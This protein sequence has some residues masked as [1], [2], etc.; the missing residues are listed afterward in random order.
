MHEYITIKSSNHPENLSET[1]GGTLLCSSELHPDKIGIN[2]SSH[3]T[4]SQCISHSS[5]RHTGSCTVA[6]AQHQCPETA[7]RCLAFRNTIY[8]LCVTILSFRQIPTFICL[9]SPKIKGKKNIS[10]IKACNHTEWLQKYMQQ[11]YKQENTFHI[12]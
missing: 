2:C 8:T 11:I 7:Y 6:I 1:K 4:V 9:V 3:L 5:K 12:K 10:T